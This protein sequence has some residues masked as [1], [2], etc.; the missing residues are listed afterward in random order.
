MKSRTRYGLSFLL[1]LIAGAGVSS[2]AVAAPA[3]PSEAPKLVMTDPAPNGKASAPLY[4]IHALFNVPVD[5]KLSKFEVTGPGG[6][7]VDV[8][9]L[10][11]MSPDGKLLMAMPKEPLPAGTYS[12]KW[13]TMAGTKPLDGEFS[14]TVQ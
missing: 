1:C 2:I 12:V 8:G 6:K 7:T 4:M 14:F 5:P 10:Q 9:A 3:P 13:H 11:L